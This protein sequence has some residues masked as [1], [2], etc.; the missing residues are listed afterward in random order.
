M[1]FFVRRREVS[2]V[3]SRGSHVPRDVMFK[4]EMGYICHTREK[5]HVMR[6]R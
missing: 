1:L 5:S 6:V 4:S 2:Y 3:Y